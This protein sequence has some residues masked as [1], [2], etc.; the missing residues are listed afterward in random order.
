M[1]TLGNTPNT[2]VLWSS[3]EGTRFVHIQV[4]TFVPGH[5]TCSVGMKA[6]KDFG[7]NFFWV[8]VGMPEPGGK[9]GD[10]ECLIKS[11][12]LQL[13]NIFSGAKFEPSPISR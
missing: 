1:V 4:K 13:L 11:W 5:R 8:L 2:D 3:I 12:L 9:L 7:G 10:L 6:E